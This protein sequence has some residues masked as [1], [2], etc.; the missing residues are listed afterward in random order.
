[1]EIADKGKSFLSSGSGD[2]IE[3]EGGI[4]GQGAGSNYAIDGKKKL[5]EYKI[6]KEEIGKKTVRGASEIRVLPRL[7]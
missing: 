5:M 6:K 4:R 1:M 7:T 3:H 2:V